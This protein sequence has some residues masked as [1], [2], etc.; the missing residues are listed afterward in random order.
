MNGSRLFEVNF[1]G[2]DTRGAMFAANGY[3]TVL[4]N[5]SGG[6]TTTNTRLTSKIHFTFSEGVEVRCEDSVGHNISS[7]QKAS[8]CIVVVVHTL[9]KMACSRFSFSS[10]KLTFHINIFH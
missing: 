9:W 7:L 10:Y 2:D 4:C 6:Q 5:V 3:T 1:V 8:K